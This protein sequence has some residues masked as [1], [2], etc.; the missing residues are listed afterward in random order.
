MEIKEYPLPLVVHLA[1]FS[2][3]VIP[4]GG[5]LG[6]AFVWFLK[7]EKNPEIQPHA[8]KA[9]NWQITVVLIQ[10]LA[11]IS[12]FGV[13]SI[14]VSALTPAANNKV[15]QVQKTEASGKAVYDQMI[16][17]LKKNNETGNKFLLVIRLIGLG[18]FLFNILNA[19]FILLNSYRAYKG[20][21][22]KY[23]LSLPIFKV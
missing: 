3:L 14:S 8:Y 20:E 1:A 16:S 23:P 13:T 4:F 18:L 2:Y 6:P 10:L 21:P 5:P 9:M 17:D 11:M 7:R 22:V 15:E 12:I 19:V